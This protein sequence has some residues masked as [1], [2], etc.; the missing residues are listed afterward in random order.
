MH[1]V[2]RIHS[3]SD[4]VSL[5]VGTIEDRGVVPR[6]VDWHRLRGSTTDQSPRYG[7]SSSLAR[8]RRVELLRKLVSTYG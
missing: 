7:Y 2:H 1:L 5:V 3:W 8:S 6:N 4:Q